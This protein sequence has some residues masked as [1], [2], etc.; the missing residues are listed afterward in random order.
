MKN[1][2]I[3]LVLVYN[4]TMKFYH[5]SKLVIDK[6]IV[7]GSDATNDYGPSFYVTLD[8]E[9]AKSWACKNNAI[10]V[11]NKYQIKDS[12]YES[13]KVLDLTDKTKYSILN[14]IAILMRFRTLDNAFKAKNKLVLEFLEQ[15]YI[16]VNEYDVIKGFRADDSYFTFPIKFISNDLA[17]DDLEDIFLSGNLG[18]QYAFMS[19]KAINLL[20]FCGVIECD[21][22]YLGHYYHIVKSATDDFQTLINKPRDPNKTYI[23]DLMRKKNGL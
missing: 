1:S 19:G 6:P 3:L 21:M 15:Y 10:G 23:L 9:S 17:F 5:G 8:L 2:D 14:W 18:I 4:T 13:L 11:V 12:D 16:D 7:K 22:K 20:K